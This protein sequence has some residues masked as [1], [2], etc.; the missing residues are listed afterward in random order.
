MMEMTQRN[1]TDDFVVK[2][3]YAKKGLN[4]II[5][6]DLKR[7]IFRG[8]VFSDGRLQEDNL[9]KDYG[10]S[11]TPIR[12]ALRRLEQEKI[13]EKLHY[14]GYKVKGLSIKD[15]EEIFGIRS[16]LESYAASLATGRI[17]KDDITRMETIIKKSQEALDNTDYEAFIELNTEF[18]ACLYAAGKSEHL[19]RILQN[20]WD[21]FY[22]Y[23]KVILRTRHNMEDSLKNHMI[24]MEKMKEGDRE[25][26]ERLVREHVDK[27]LLV[28]KEELRKTD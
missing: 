24:M 17:T 5:Y 27:A 7:K 2:R 11:R 9:T 28:L 12:D 15:V 6:E 26:V 8:D 3:N 21:Y 10:T 13:I 1:E 14:G 23:R 16:V 20:L 25:T 22:R 19:L 18:H 4:E